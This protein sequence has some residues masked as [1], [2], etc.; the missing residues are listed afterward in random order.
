VGKIARDIATRGDFTAGDFAHPTRRGHQTCNWRCLR[1][2][3]FGVI[4]IVND[5]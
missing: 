1:E 5:N 3:N 2:Y 4:I